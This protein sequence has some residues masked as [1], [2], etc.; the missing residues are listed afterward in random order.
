MM[1][2]L[3]EPVWDREMQKAALD[4]L[5]NEKYVLGESVFKFEE[6]FAK[7]IG[8]DYAVSCSSGTMAEWLLLQAIKPKTVVVP[9]N[10]FHTVASVVRLQRRKLQLEDV[11]ERNACMENVAL[12]KPGKTCVIATHLYGNLCKIK[13]HTEKV[14]LIEDCSQAAGLS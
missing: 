4:A 1:I 10:T 2:S 14:S 6:E 9:D 5:N 7:Y 8:V 12:N 3:N 11:N 13:V